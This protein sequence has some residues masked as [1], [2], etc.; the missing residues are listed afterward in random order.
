MPYTV[1]PRWSH[2]DFPTAAELNKYST[3]QVWLNGVLSSLQPATEDISGNTASFV[4]VWRWLHYM[5]TSGETATITDPS[6][7]VPSVSL[8]ASVG[9]MSAYDLSDVS[10]LI[11]GQVYT[12][13][14]CDYV[15]EDY[16]S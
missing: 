7:A 1:P 9:S 13:S 16:S 15:A 12:V 4:H 11:L 2:G 3:N 8:P 10:W 5:T 6:G 14:G